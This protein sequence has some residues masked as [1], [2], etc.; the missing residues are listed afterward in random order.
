VGS[1]LTALTAAAVAAALTACAGGSLASSSPAPNACRS[2][3]PE[4]GVWGPDRLQVLSACTVAAGVVLE[5]AREAD[6]DHH[7]WF[8]VDQGYERLLNSE[9]HFQARPA[10]LAEITPAC[11]LDTNPADGSA[12]ARCPPASL[13]IPV[14]GD[15]ISVRGPWVLDREHGWNE[16]HPVESI[17]IRGG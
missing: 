9:N 12:A 2:A 10:M 17:T 14:I 13:P 11:P 8:R 15:H 5:V 6:G 16:I 3:A 1:R 4:A 7:I